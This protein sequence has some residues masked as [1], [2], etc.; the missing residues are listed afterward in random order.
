MPRGKNDS[1]I[2]YLVSLPNGEFDIYEGTLRQVK[3]A[4]AENLDEHSGKIKVQKLGPAKFL[5]PVITVR[6]EDAT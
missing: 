3:D 2:Q 4:L 5:S 1:Q 6:F